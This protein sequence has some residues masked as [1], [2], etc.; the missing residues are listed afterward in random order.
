LSE[1]GLRPDGGFVVVRYG[2]VFAGSGKISKDEKVHP[3]IP[4]ER[5]VL[6]E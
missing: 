3:Q 4:K 6:V 1:L 2:P 5:R